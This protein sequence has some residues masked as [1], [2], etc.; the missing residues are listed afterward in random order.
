LKYHIL[1]EFEN[2]KIKKQV[3]ILKNFQMF[4]SFK[5]SDLIKI[6]LSSKIMEFKRNQIVY[7]END[8]SVYVYFILEG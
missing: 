4:I 1:V 2:N 6:Y 5:D 8:D 7:E 3:A